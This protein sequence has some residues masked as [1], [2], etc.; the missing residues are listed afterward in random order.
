MKRT[1]S[2]ILTAAFLLL[3]G[4]VQIAE[5][6]NVV[7]YEAA[8][9]DAAE[10]SAPEGTAAP[11]EPSVPEETPGALIGV[12]AVSPTEPLPSETPTVSAEATPD[13]APSPM[14][15]FTPSPTPAYTVEDMEEKEAYLNA[16]SANLREGPGM[17]YAVLEELFEYEKL[18][19]TGK[20][21]EWYRV[22]ADNEAGFILGEFVEFGTAPTPKPTPSY[23]VKEMDD[24]AA[25]V[26]AG[27]ANLRKGPGKDYDIIVELDR[28]EKITVTGTS[29]D[30]YRV[31]YGSKKGFITKELVKIGAVPTSSPSPTPSP[32]PSLKPSASPGAS[33]SPSVKPTATASPTKQ[34]QSIGTSSGGNGYGV[35]PYDYFSD[36]GGFTAAELLLLAQVVQEEAKGTS[37]EARAAVANTIYNRYLSSNYPNDIETIIFQKNQYTVADD[38]AEI[39][40]VKPVAD[41]V[42]AVKQIFV[43][44]DTFLP[45]DVHFFRQKSRGTSW[46]DKRVYY[47]TYGN[48]A[49]FRSLYGE[50][51][52]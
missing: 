19:V 15:E 28:N 34:P 30:W 7:T 11:T 25:Y 14:P 16:G 8:P 35:N 40:S 1:L 33:P 51:A 23:K 49:F 32:S 3:T 27:S 10:M 18:T 43:N 24:T 47:A 45:E 36:G 29:G 6:G 48:N 31:E 44:H 13:P 41:T 20:S 17:E 22:E 52:R 42:K 21:G 26:N 46:G 39:R 9:P 2:F 37:V 12:D 4:C 50:Y 38:E 5:T